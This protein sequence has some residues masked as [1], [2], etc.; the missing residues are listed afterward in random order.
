M[1]QVRGVL[2]PEQ[3]EELK[4]RLEARH[5][6]KGKGGGGNQPSGKKGAKPLG[7]DG[8]KGK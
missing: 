4:R 2:T 1:E 3:R 5:A 8:G 6:K 7:G